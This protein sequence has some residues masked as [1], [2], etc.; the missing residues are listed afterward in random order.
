M[1]N[2]TGAGRIVPHFSHAPENEQ[3]YAVHLFEATPAYRRNLPEPV[4]MVFCECFWCSRYQGA[5]LFWM[6]DFPALPLHG[7]AEPGDN[8]SSPG[9]MRPDA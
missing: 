2:R 5:G 7:G 3:G 6:A 4:T 1:R 9:S 8:S